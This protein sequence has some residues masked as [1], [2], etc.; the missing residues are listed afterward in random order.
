MM[1]ACAALLGWDTVAPSI[2]WR[3][4]QTKGFVCQSEP[5]ELSVSGRW[6]WRQKHECMAEEANAEGEGRLWNTNNTL[7]ETRTRRRWCECKKKCTRKVRE[8]GW[9]LRHLPW[10]YD[11]MHTK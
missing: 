3:S 2:V 11:F 4:V 6:A 9:F 7:M 1:K 10:T 5:R 8:D